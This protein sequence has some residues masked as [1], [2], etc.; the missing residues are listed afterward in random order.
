M[1]RH[2]TLLIKKGVKNS[3]PKN[4]QPVGLSCVP[5]GNAPDRD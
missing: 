1:K 2:V 5:T 4:N 3:P